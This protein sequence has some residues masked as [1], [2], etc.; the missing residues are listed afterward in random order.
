[1]NSPEKL[2]RDDG[3]TI[4]YRR[5]AGAAP[6]IVFLGGFHSDM[7]GN[8]AMYLEDYCRRRGL[9]F[10]RFDHFGHG[11]SSGEVSMGT[12]GRWAE[13]AI[14]VVDSLT[15]E[16]Q[17]LVGSSMG[18]WIMLLAALARPARIDALVGVAAAPDFTEDFLWPRLDAVQR[19]QLL[20]TGMVVLPSEYDPAGY[21]YRLSLFEDGK[22]HLVLRNAIAIDCP[23][24]LLHGMADTSVPW[25]R[26]LSLAERLTS[27][28]VIV[29]LVKDGDHRLSRESDLAR[30]GRTLDEL[31]SR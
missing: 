2:T 15:Q 19:Q 14:T 13:D 1:M 20:E 29:T 5:L 21:T 22:Q 31:L 23:V 24:R 9:A 10:L 28:D 12:I 26:S 8:K 17:I 27:S 7:T 3:A 6:G 11:A 4:A 30:L 16:R 18:G 25:Q